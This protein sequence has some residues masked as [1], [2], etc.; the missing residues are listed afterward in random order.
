MPETIAQFQLVEPMGHSLL[1]D[2]HRAR[3]LDLG[4]TVT[5][6]LI[7]AAFTADPRTLESVL[8]AARRVSALSHPAVAAVY[9]SGEDGGRAFIA[10]EFVAGQRLSAMVSGSALNRRRALDLAVQIADG[11]AAA[12]ALGLTHA[13]VGSDRIMVTPKGAAKVL[14]VGMFDWTSAEG[15]ERRDDRVGLGAVLFE[16]LVGRP[17]RV[18]WPAEL[19]LAEIPAEA[20]PVLHALTSSRAGEQYE[21]MATAAAALRDLAVSLP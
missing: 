18:G 8:S 17:L 16:M 13:A 20:Q 21:S 2:L 9:G 11:L 15:Q 14:D 19:R 12:H 7:G 5:V 10:S 3:E 1:G 4:R 6:C